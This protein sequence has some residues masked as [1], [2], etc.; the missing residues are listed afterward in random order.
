MSTTTRP[1]TR[2]R[3]E[4][5]EFEKFWLAP[6]AE[7]S[8]TS[9]GR[10]HPSEPHPYRTEFQKD[11][12]RIIHTT[13]FRRLQ[14]KTQVFINYEG[15]YYRTRLTHTTEAA[16][17]ARTIA[18]ALKVNE[19]LTEGITLAHDL[20]HSAFG[21]SG[22]VTLDRLMLE[23]MGLD[24]NDPANAGKGFNHTVQ[25]LRVVDRL[26]RRWPNFV[27]LNLTWEMREGIVKHGSKLVN[28]VSTSNVPH[29]TLI[30]GGSYG[31]GNYGMCGRAYDPRFLFTWPNSR[32]AV[33]GGEQAAGVMALLAEEQA[34]SRGQEPDRAAIETRSQQTRAMFE[35]QSSAFYAT[36]RLWDDGI[37][38]PRHTRQALILALQVVSLKK[39]APRYGVFRM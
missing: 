6:Y 8:A 14:Y 21:H 26:E 24:P 32:I 23:R 17:M 19:E 38:D 15:D 35:Q 33:M 2:T 12:D 13:A 4:L 16:Q 3:Q 31:A 18:R 20:G 9:R 25:S 29:L 34:R 37:L 5:E 39:K 1:A 22:E 28:A 27:G 10:Q 7:K 36:A 11:R 30:V